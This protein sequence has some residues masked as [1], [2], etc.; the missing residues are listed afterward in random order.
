[1]KGQKGHIACY[2]RQ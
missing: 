1:M 2:C